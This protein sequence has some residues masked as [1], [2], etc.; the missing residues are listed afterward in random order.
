MSGQGSEN[1]H[2]FPQSALREIPQRGHA[3]RQ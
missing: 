3:E 1:E 2:D